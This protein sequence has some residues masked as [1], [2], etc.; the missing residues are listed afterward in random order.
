MTSGTFA[1]GY[2]QTWAIDA[3]P[4]GSR[5]AFM[6]QVKL[7]YGVIGKIIELFARRG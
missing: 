5:F 7:P 4:P 1:K 6:E 3:T 2:E